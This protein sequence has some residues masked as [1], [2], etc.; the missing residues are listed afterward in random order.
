MATREELGAAFMNAHK[1]G[2]TAR[3]GVLAVAIRAMDAQQGPQN[4][5]GAAQAG[6]QLALPTPGPAM[7]PEG[8]MGARPTTPVGRGSA[9]TNPDSLEGATFP[10]PATGDLKGAIQSQ[11]WL[12]KVL[13]GIGTGPVQAAQSAKQLAGVPVDPQDIENQRSIASTGA[14]MAGNIAGNIAMLAAPGG[15]ALRGV[16]AGIKMLPKALQGIA[17]FAAVPSEAAAEGALLNPTLEGE[18]RG[19]NAVQAAVLSKALQAAGNV[20]T[21]VV[22]PTSEA[23]AIMA[24]GGQPTVGQG[25]RGTMASYVENAAAEVPLIGPLIKARQARAEQ[26]VVDIAARRGDPTGLRMNM[27]D[28]PPVGRGQHFINREADANEA[29]DAVLKGR[30]IPVGQDFRIAAGDAGRTELKGVPDYMVSKFEDDMRRFLPDHNGRIGA[31][32]WKEM[33]NNVRQRQRE[34][35]DAYGKSGRGEDRDL[36]KAYGAVDDVLIKIRN[37]GMGADDR[38]RLEAIDEAHANNVIMARAAAYPR[39]E[40]EHIGVNN[41]VRSVEQGTPDSLLIKNQGRMQDITEPAKSVFPATSKAD[42]LERRLANL[43]AGT[44][45]GGTALAT[46]H[47]GVLAAVPVAALSALIGSTRSGAKAMMGQFA[48]QKRMAEILRNK[49]TQGAIAAEAQDMVTP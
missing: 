28:E 2:D 39:Q 43:T 15:A 24:L 7:A 1:A 13:A 10:L 45:L 47:P 42:A 49:Y 33:Q 44:V 9:Q 12:D 5:Q 14:G 21:G 17:R 30:H 25:A 16:E 20:A 35:Y 36:A 31:P 48:A 4:A 3:A 37:K 23:R 41:L 27:A 8:P 38:I 32:R 18:S 46:G 19:K 22:K 34:A 26:E 40:G 6:G 11:P 29:Y